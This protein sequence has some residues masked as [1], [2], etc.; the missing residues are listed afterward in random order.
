MPTLPTNHKSWAASVTGCVL[1]HWQAA[2]FP[3]WVGSSGLHW[4]L[5]RREESSKAGATGLKQSRREQA[6]WVG[7]YSFPHWPWL[8]WASR[9]EGSS[10]EPLFHVQNSKANCQRECWRTPHSEQPAR[11]EGRVCQPPNSQLA[12]SNSSCQFKTSK[13]VNNKE[14]WN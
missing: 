11:R 6:S 7:T 2:S 1:S 13:G 14:L 8:Q 9:W 10:S 5:S 3:E 4:G 12:Q